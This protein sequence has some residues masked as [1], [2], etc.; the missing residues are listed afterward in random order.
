MA[1]RP[2]KRQKRPVVGASSSSETESTEK[3]Q[4]PLQKLGRSEKADPEPS[5]GRT[6]QSFFTASVEQRHRS[7]QETDDIDLAEL[8]DLIEDDSILEEELRTQGSPGVSSAATAEGRNKR[9]A[10]SA[11]RSRNEEDLS[12][13][14]SQRFIQ[15]GKTL[16]KA[17]N[18]A[19]ALS[20]CVEEDTR[21]WTDKYRPLS[22][23]ELAV[24]KK[25]VDDV[26]R[27]LQD[28]LEGRSRKRMLILKGASGT[29]KTTTLSLLSQSLKADMLEWHNPTASEFATGYIS[30][31]GQFDDFINR[32]GRLASLEL[33]AE[34]KDQ[35]TAVK[36]R[37]R[38]S[39]SPN[40]RKI[41]LVD[42]FPNTFMSSSA[43]LQAFRAILQ[44]FLAKNISSWNQAPQ[45]T[46]GQSNQVIPLVLVISETLLGSSSSGDNFTVHRL[47][48]PEILNHPAVSQ[49][50]FNPVARTFLKK[51][52]D[53]VLLKDAKA[54]GRRKLPGPS[55][56]DRL[57]E[58][59]DIRSALASLE[60][61]CLRGEDEDE[62][63]GISA[64][65]K[66]KKS[67][68]GLA[69]LSRREKES[70]QVVTRR[71][72]SLG[73]FHAVGKVVYNKRDEVLKSDT[74][75][76][77][78]AQPPCYL[79]Q[80]VRKTRSQVAVDELMDQT[81][82]DTQTFIS[83]LHE[84]YVLSCCG[85]SPG[86]TLDAINGC[87][88]SLSDSDLLSTGYGGRSNIGSWSNGLGGDSLSG[89]GKDSLRHDE[90]CFQT[91]VRGILFSLPFPVKRSPP[92]PT[93]AGLR[94]TSSAK[95]RGDA[96]RMFYPAALKLWRT[97]E[98]IEGAVNLWVKRFNEGYQILASCNAPSKAVSCTSKPSKDN[99]TVSTDQSPDHALPCS[100]SSG[101]SQMAL[102]RLPYM[103]KILKSRSL[104]SSLQLLEIEKVTSFHGI[105]IQ[106]EEISD[107][108]DQLREDHLT[109]EK[110]VTARR[111]R[112]ERGMDTEPSLEQ[113]VGSLGLSSQMRGQAEKLVLSDDDIEDD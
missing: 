63:V 67:S 90:I 3:S 49:I 97:K 80:H 19:S 45:S 10:T 9:P 78:L 99:F 33:L 13:K 60:F 24:H 88:D 103:G 7:T 15:A 71:E 18:T 109:H 89:A 14:G 75:L 106:S 76:Q 46:F 92:L 72:A 39:S 36:T 70:P 104:S 21:P 83:T 2:A 81:G 26:R 62:S 47:L 48:G 110:R 105:G 113:E 66:T 44:Q 98:E 59:G 32:G 61:L 8:D 108:E 5:K 69:S 87:I 102:E 20:Q 25:K 53:L 100:G 37:G 27:W 38:Q 65:G 23:D 58:I 55:L 64:V 51:A 22:L 77:P 30:V 107:F 79:G 35:I 28:V 41:I 68:R 57:G 54:S 17:T 101:R 12:C 93:Q 29:G 31:L 52:L 16:N 86:D 34:S 11:A 1:A 95:Q 85:T 43:P 42:E 91:A 84:N 73:M 96:H 82:T 40:E 6:I 56:L 94:K 74:S 111:N 50:E 112:N 4:K